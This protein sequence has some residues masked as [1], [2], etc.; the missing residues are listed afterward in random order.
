MSHVHGSALN[1]LLIINQSRR[2]TSKRH[3][4]RVS[5]LV[6]IV[7]HFMFTLSFHMKV[8]VLILR[9]QIW[10]GRIRLNLILFVNPFYLFQDLL[11][12]ICF[13]VHSLILMLNYVLSIKIGFVSNSVVFYCY[14]IR[15]NKLSCWQRLG[16]LLVFLD[17]LGR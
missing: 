10:E 12:I 1:F 3:I 4:G 7:V 13:R 16:E 17:F 9:L 8:L 5:P 6:S 2:S 14:I 15:V 11:I